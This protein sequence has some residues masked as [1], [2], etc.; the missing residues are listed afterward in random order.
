MPFNLPL[1]YLWD[2]RPV[3]TCNHYTVD[4][5]IQRRQKLSGAS[6]PHRRPICERSVW[7]RRCA[8][9]LAQWDVATPPLNRSLSSLSRLCSLISICHVCQ[10]EKTPQRRAWWVKKRVCYINLLPCGF[11]MTVISCIFALT[12]CFWR[13]LRQTHQASSFHARQCRWCTWSFSSL[14]PDQMYIFDA[15]L[16]C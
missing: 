10:K 14:M 2:C 7:R 13:C 9:S 3:L 8:H 11:C 4:A 15:A 1:N 12:P 5:W 6:H 16:S